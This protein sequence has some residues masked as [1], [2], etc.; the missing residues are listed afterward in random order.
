MG[1]VLSL[2]FTRNAK[3]TIQEL[4]LLKYSNKTQTQNIKEWLNGGHSARE[5]PTGIG[6]P[7]CRT[8]N[9]PREFF[10]ELQEGQQPLWG[11]GSGSKWGWHAVILGLITKAAYY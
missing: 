5:K 11:Q 2:S 8:P 4:L 1:N 6:D 7:V 9:H 3:A 10:P